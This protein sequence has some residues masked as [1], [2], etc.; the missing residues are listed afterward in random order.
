MRMLLTAAA[1]CVATPAAAQ[2]H[3]N[4]ADTKAVLTAIDA[5]FTGLTTKD[6]AAIT[7]ATWPEGRATGTSTSA[8]G[9]ARVTGSD[10]ATFAGRIATIPGKPVERNVDPHVHVDGDIAMVWTPYVFTLDGKFSH[11]GTNHFDLVRKAGVWKIL[12]VT[13]TQRKTGCPP[14]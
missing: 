9:E 14:A 3:A 5:L 8:S 6:A 10:W 1:L 7:A 2:E 13:W 4:D 12:N 11:C